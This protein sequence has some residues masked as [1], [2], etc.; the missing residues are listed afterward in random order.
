MVGGIV[1]LYTGVGGIPRDW[2]DAREP[3]PDWPFVESDVS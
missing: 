2:R 3:L 1:S